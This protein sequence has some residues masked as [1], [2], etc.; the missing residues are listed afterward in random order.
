VNISSKRAQIAAA[1]RNRRLALSLDFLLRLRQLRRAHMDL[2]HTQL[3][4]KHM[5]ELLCALVQLT[6]SPANPARSQMARF[7]TWLHRDLFDDCDGSLLIAALL[8]AQGSSR[9]KSRDA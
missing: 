6:S 1:E 7:A 3:Y 2:V 9:N 5:H 4:R 8:M